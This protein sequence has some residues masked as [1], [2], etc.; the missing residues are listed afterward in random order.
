MT[1]QIFSNDSKLLSIAS[2]ATLQGWSFSK[3]R[4]EVD[5]LTVDDNELVISIYTDAIQ[6]SPLYLN[7]NLNIC[8]MSVHHVCEI[9]SIKNGYYIPPEGFHEI[10]KLSSKNLSMFYGRK[11]D[12]KYAVS[13][14]GY[15]N[16]ITCPIK[17]LAD[18]TWLVR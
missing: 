15:D 2:E 6:S 12:Y 16:Y 10:M 9:L 14:S 5:L 8:S 3:Q 17:K 4:L 1:F 13:F 7:E 11:D 18:I